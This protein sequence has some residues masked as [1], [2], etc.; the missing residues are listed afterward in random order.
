MAYT[1][2]LWRDDN[3]LGRLVAV[4]VVS[5]LGFLGWCVQCHKENRRV[6]SQEAF[7]K[8]EFVA[9]VVYE[10][11]VDSQK[12]LINACESHISKSPHSI[13]NENGS[14]RE[15]YKVNEKINVDGLPSPKYL[16]KKGDSFYPI[17]NVFTG[18]NSLDNFKSWLKE[19]NY[20]NYDFDT[21]YQGTIAYNT[22]E[23]VIKTKS[24]TIS[25]IAFF[26]SDFD[27]LYMWDGSK[28]RDLSGGLTG[29]A[30]GSEKHY[31]DYVE[32]LKKL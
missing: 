11:N 28:V 4:F 14:P 24:S 30:N 23:V 20:P 8:N 32:W 13:F 26:K 19:N 7:V 3:P 9:I 22:K 18:K 31:L 29:Q 15:F 12:K 17:Y 1:N 25:F 10:D 21:K 16:Q 6:D 27:R 5:I 2:P